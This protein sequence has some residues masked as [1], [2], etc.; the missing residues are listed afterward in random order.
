LRNKEIAGMGEESTDTLDI[1]WGAAAIARFIN[2]T[3]R[4]VHHMLKKQTKEIIAAR[5][6]GGRW[7]ADKEG[8]RQQF[9][10]RAE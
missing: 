3:P 1:L 5:K 9:C 6:V 8:L 4:Q 10:G 2:R 7:C